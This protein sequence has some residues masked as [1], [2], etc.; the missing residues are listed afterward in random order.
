[1]LDPH[2]IAFI[3]C[4]RDEVQYEDLLQSLA[5][6]EVPEGYTAEIITASGSRGKAAGY[7]EA[8]QRSRAKYKVYVDEQVR[9]LEKD[10][11]SFLLR[12]FAADRQIG[13]L[14]LAGACVLP[15]S[16]ETMQTPKRAGRMMFGAGRQAVIWSEAAAFMEVQALD[17][18]LL[19]TCQD[20]PWRED[21]F[22][23]D[24]LVVAAQCQ[25]FR[26]KGYRVGVPPQEKCYAVCLQRS[27]R[28][29]MMAQRQFMSEYAREIYPLVTVMI[30]TCNRPAF[31]RIAVE[32]ALAQTYLHLEI[33][34]MD[35]STD[36]RTAEMM[37][38]YEAD[39][40]VRYFRQA[41]KSAYENWMAA[42]NHVK[43][44]P[45]PYVNWLMDDDVFCADKIARMMDFYL[46]NDAVS[47][48]TSYRQR[49]DQDG[50]VLPEDASTARI[51][52]D[53]RI[54]PGCEAGKKLLCQ[55]LNFI[56]GPT[57]V[58]I[59]KSLLKA[60]DFGWNER[61]G[62]EHCRYAYPDVPTWLQLLAQGDMAYI[63]EPL[64]QYRV[65]DGQVK[66]RFP[67]AVEGPIC[68]ASA[69]R[70]AYEQK[71][72]LT[73]PAEF[74]L[75]VENWLMRAIGILRTATE[76]GEKTPETD[77]L[78]HLVQEFTAAAAALQS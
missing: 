69:I 59:K 76:Q 75:A 49:I 70:Y 73:V 33:V 4:V 22:A 31:C 12:A 3:T 13:M 2:K 42:R 32:S 47:L 27:F 29:E 6:L 74:V 46:V 48:V 62:Q 24:S 28:A 57:A 14:G 39:P 66:Q 36:E 53:T 45:S 72:F 71:I 34:V 7:Q 18:Y 56:G 50:N 26:R 61:L 77:F 78:W 21:L 58:L 52:E 40:R 30:P 19:V 17:E 16:G 35:N 38:V 1:M 20:L 64:S 51:A 41:G 37:Q 5:V 67:M 54:L 68:W 25:E 43:R 15:T 10:F 63:V 8:M 44:S 55:G 11:L 65:H 9:I 60:G 23:G